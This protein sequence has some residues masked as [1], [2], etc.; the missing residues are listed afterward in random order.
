MSDMNT[1][2]QDWL[3]LLALVNF[4]LCS[5]IGWACI[6]RIAVM[7]ADTTR[8][9][10]RAAYA[11]VLVCASASGLAPILWREWPGPGQLAM[12]VAV[13]AVLALGVS[14]WRHGPPTYARSA[15]APLD[16]LDAA[17]ADLDTRPPLDQ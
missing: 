7:S 13:L 2:P 10:Y 9:T 12:S 6:C 11:V 14:S 15:P 5:A 1:W 8:K 17:F 4:A 3:Y 16:A